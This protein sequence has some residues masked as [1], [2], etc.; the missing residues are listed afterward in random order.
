MDI[1]DIEHLARLARIDLSDEEKESLRV[2]I[3]N[4]VAL[5]DEVQA[6][7]VTTHTTPQPGI[8]HTVMRDDTDPHES[9]I[10]TEKLLDSAPKRKG[11]YVEVKNI[12]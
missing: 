10:Y 4:I 3:T 9:G 8:V 6:S 7:G 11:Q 2:D 5:V 1:K 12:L